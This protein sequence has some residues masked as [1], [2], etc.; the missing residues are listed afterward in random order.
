VASDVRLAKFPDRVLADLSHHGR[1]VGFFTTVA[2]TCVL[3]SQAW[4]IRGAW[5]LAAGLWVLGIL[6]G[7]RQRSPASRR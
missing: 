4:V 6:T 2:A 3:G 7:R 5:A 1:A